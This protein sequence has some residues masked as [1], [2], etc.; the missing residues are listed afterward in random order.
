MKLLK[1]HRENSEGISVAESVAL[2]SPENESSQIDIPAAK[3]TAIKNVFIAHGSYLFGAIESEGNVVIEGCVEGNISSHLDIRIDIGGVI[4]GDLHATNIVINGLITG[5]CYAESV[6]LLEKGRVDGDVFTENLSI[7]RGGVFI[8]QSCP[9]LIEKGDKEN[10]VKGF[11]N[12]DIRVK[13]NYQS[14]KKNNTPADLNEN[15]DVI[16]TDINNASMD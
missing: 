3:S 4:K 2:L 1:K 5:R 8:G 9:S 11:T 10:L 16:N 14:A 7:E 12:R 6:A 15:P 13:D